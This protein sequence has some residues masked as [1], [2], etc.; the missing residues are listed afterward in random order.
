[1][2]RLSVQVHALEIIIKH[3]Y[4]AE[5]VNKGYVLSVMCFEHLSKEQYVKK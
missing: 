3:S 5:S 1:M 4:Y 2:S